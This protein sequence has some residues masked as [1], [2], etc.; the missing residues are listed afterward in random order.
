M[1][2]EHTPLVNVGTHDA[3]AP[4]FASLQRGPFTTVVAVIVVLLS[5]F[6][7]TSA[8]YDDSKYQPSRYVAFRD[9][10]VMLLLGFGYLM[11]FLGR[12]GLGSV[13][14]TM[15]LTAVAI[16]L[17][18]AVE[19]YVRVLSGRA[20]EDESAS[21]LRI[22]L[23]TII[24]GEFFAATVLISF[25][26]IIGRASPLQLI[27]MVLGESVFYAINK[28]VFVLGFLQTEDVGGVSVRKHVALSTCF[29]FAFIYYT[30]MYESQH[31]LY[32]RAIIMIIH[33]P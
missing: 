16:P 13:G 23:D 14:F 19:H 17:N 3:L 24:D 12:Y 18:V 15:L 2:T 1:P 32:I 20:D 30:Y 10:M 9:I 27:V 22:G 4:D 5:I 28:V 6:F 26:A 11:T 8:D 21:S 7:A 31:L 29:A 33:S 25:G